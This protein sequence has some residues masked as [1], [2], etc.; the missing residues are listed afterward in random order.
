MK[1]QNGEV[2]RRIRHP[3]PNQ[4]VGRQPPWQPGQSGNPAGRPIG[5]RAKLSA[6]FLADVYDLWQRRGPE[7]LAEMAEKEPGQFARLVAGL[8]PTQLQ[9][10][11]TTK[12]YLVVPTR[13]TIGDDPTGEDGPLI[14]HEPS[15]DQGE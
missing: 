3:H 5:A 8:I 10:E 6:R 2:T 11:I 15:A 1:P 7:V 12:A 13:R 14:E 9:A 4:K